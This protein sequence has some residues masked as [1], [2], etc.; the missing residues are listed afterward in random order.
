AEAFV[1]LIKEFNYTHNDLANILGKSRS[2]ITNYLR[3]LNLPKEI[4]ELIALKR[5]NVGHAKIIV[6][7]EFPM[8]LAEEI[9]LKNLSVR[10]VEQLVKNKKTIKT[11]NKP[12]PNQDN[13]S[14]DIKQKLNELFKECNIEVK[15]NT[16]GSGY[17]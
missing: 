11:N 4:K 5:L 12:I 17:I 14:K 3:I 6:N 9:V 1:Q 16:N 8:E 13:F 2:H 7:Y 15:T 10:D